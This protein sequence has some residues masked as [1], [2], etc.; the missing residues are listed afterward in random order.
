ML[1]ADSAAALATAA[2]ALTAG[3]DAAGDFQFLARE[4]Q[5]QFSAAQPLRLA[6]VAKDITDLRTK[7]DAAIAAIQREPTT[8]QRSPAGWYFS[9]SASSATTGKIAF[10]FPGQGSQYVGMG[11][12]LASAF[13][14]SQAIWD[15]AADLEF[16]QGGR[17]QDVVFP[18]PVFSD[19]ERKVLEEQLR[20]TDWAQPAIGVASLSQL[21]VL[22]RLG[23]HPDVTGGHSFGEVTALYAAGALDQKAFLH[24]ARKRGELMAEAAAMFP[25][26]MTA[27]SHPAAE[28]AEL[29]ASWN[30]GVVIANH[31]APDQV[32]ISGIESAIEASEERLRKA[33]I[34]YQRL[35]VATAFH[36]TVVRPATAPFHAYLNHVPVHAPVLPV[37]ANSTASIYSSVPDAVRETLADQ[38]ALPVL[39][40]E[41]LEAMYAAGVRVFVE[42]GPGTVLTNLVKNCL[43]DRPHYAVAIDRKGEHGLTSLWQALAQL[44]VAG[45]PL[46]LA[47]L[48]EDVSVGAD[49]RTRRMPKLAVPL[50]GV[51]YAKPYPPANGAAGL[52][53]PNPVRRESHAAVP[54]GIAVKPQNVSPSVNKQLNDTNSRPSEHIV[55]AGN[56]HAAPQAQPPAPV[57]TSW[58]TPTPAPVAPSAPVSPAV[59]AAPAAPAMQVA[60]VMP[61]QPTPVVAAQPQPAAS[62]LPTTAAHPAG[63]LTNNEALAWA[64]VFQEL[65]R[66]TADA[67]MS[68]LQV[69]EQSMRSLESMLTLG[70]GGSQPP[71]IPAPQQM[72]APQPLPA[73]VYQPPAPLA[74]APAPVQRAVLVPTAPAVV[75]PVAAAP[76]GEDLHGIMME[77]VTEKTGYPTEMLE[78]GMALDTDLGIDSIKRVEIL[79]AMRERVPALPEFDT[80]VMAGLRTLGE[81]VAYMDSQLGGQPAPAPSNKPASA[82]VS[83]PTAPA[84]VAPVA[85]APAGEDL[86]G[87]MM[88]VVTE[89]TGYPTEMLEPG[90]ALDTDLGIDSIKRVE[91]LAAMRER[92]PAL[93]EFDTSVMAGLRTLG[94]IV[95]YM[96]GQLAPPSGTGAAP[97]AVALASA[98][99]DPPYAGNSFPTLDPIR[100]YTL[101]AVERPLPGLTPPFLIDGT[102][103]YITDEGRGIAPAL[104]ERLRAAGA[105]AVVCSSVPA[106]ARSVICLAGLAA[107]EGEEVAS[108]ANGSAFAAAAAVAA[109]MEAQGGLFV[110]VQDTGGD[111]GLVSNPGERAWL[112]G[113]SGLAKTAAQ[114]WPQ[115]VVRALDLASDQPP[116]FAAER[117][118]GEL[119]NGGADLE[120]GLPADGRRLAF[121]SIDTPAAGGSA[122]VD[123]HSVLVVSGG[124]RGV[125]AA[126][127]IALAQAARPHIALLGRTVLEREPEAL[128]GIYD[129]AG[130]K[131]TLLAAA[132][133]QGKRLSPKELG[134][135]ADRIQAVRE[136]RSTLLALT[137][138]GAQAMYLSCDVGDRRCDGARARDRTGAMGT[139]HGDR[140][141]GRRAGRQAAG[142]KDTRGF[143]PCIWG[144]SGRLAFAADSYTG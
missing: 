143:P 123:E 11:G 95:A 105:T 23:L 7:L 127:L 16:E 24:V 113:L 56:G 50:S 117:L 27:I 122:V 129:D 99:T 9:G 101:Q 136:I 17:L 1:G 42:V 53:A 28:V 107:A 54:N 115:A 139:D 138:A 135:A 72:V 114:E 91:I 66:Q 128:S 18:R 67:H 33:G 79:A 19:D 45:V 78:P 131:K 44:V 76:A 85:A 81:I 35:P 121:S 80:S 38:I 106:E 64:G 133:A 118:A 130:L 37:Y 125:T 55:A 75:A 141:W 103:V 63:V 25:G 132:Q 83:V 92:V 43:G 10:L 41:Q 87:I 22:A 60:P 39:F 126:A 32:V 12:D 6:V 137:A 36:S 120:I 90:M 109:G 86:H 62:P 57:A 88:E 144:K 14:E 82:A 51:N 65:Q 68:F 58:S 40:A 20:A 69:A 124:G 98:A 48:W 116:N 30:T 112:G 4:T 26:A 5:R 110:T 15:H 97:V 142:R 49:P 96:D 29:L 89:K 70:V 77:V 34:R 46:N 52:A 74:A 13:A 3:Y 102:T 59:P 2:G 73:Q 111:F 134:A 71:P 140:A 31:N 108:A 94:E 93:P 104:A 47:A 100:R 8:P 84:V 119:L 21:A 61:L